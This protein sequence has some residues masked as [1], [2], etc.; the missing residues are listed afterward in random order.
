V[1]RFE[2]DELAQLITVAVAAR[3]EEVAALYAVPLDMGA[4]VKTADFSRDA[5]REVWQALFRLKIEET[6]HVPQRV[7]KIPQ[8][9]DGAP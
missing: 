5:V 1:N 4:M 6:D 3:G 2:R 7:V 9:R 8:H